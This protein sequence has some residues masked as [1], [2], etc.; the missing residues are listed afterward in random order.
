[1][2]A[3]AVI[4]DETRR[5]ILDRL[6]A[7]ATD[8]G[9]L[10][11]ELDV[12]QPHASKHLKVLRD[13]GA[14]SVEVVGNRRVYHLADDPLADVLAWAAPYFRQWSASLDRLE[15]ALAKEERT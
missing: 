10:T 2:D 9:T 7:E 15:A 1:M 4:A 14:V 11:R 3:F 13:A 6:R 12:S 8:V 5:K